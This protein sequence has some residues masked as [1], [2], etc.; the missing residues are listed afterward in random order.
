ML[1]AGAHG[2]EGAADFYFCDFIIRAGHNGG[3]FTPGEFEKLAVADQ[4][5]DPEVGQ[6]GL[7]GAEEFSG[8]A[9]FEI[10]FGDL[11]TVIRLH[12]GVET[13]LAFFGDFAAGHQDAERFCGPAADAA[14]ELVKL[15]QTEALGV[16]DHHYG[17]VGHVDANFY[18]G[19]RDQNLELAF[20]EHTHD[21]ILQVGIETAVKKA[22]FHV[23]EYFAAEFAVHL[24]G[25][26]QF[27]FFVF[28]DYRVDD[29]DL[30]SLGDLFA[31]EVPDLGGAIVGDSAGDD[32]S[33]AGR[34]F[35]EDAEVEIAVE[36]E[37]KGAGDGGGG[38][39]QDVGL[40]RIF[41]IAGIT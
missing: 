40:G 11:K 19:G 27:A 13:A 2:D 39:D 10:E 9:E 1:P 7:T 24:D 5:S 36:G 15:G 28:G 30:M 25:G 38:H 26:F 20:L 33:A 21:L 32:G 4:V 41:L 22:D 8:A 29:V 14:A 37:G 18:D 6:A 34:E 3:G 35:V 23:S 17:C 12:H 16:L 31:N